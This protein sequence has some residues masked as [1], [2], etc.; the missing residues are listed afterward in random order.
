M[1]HKKSQEGFFSALGRIMQ[2]SSDIVKDVSRIALLEFRIARLSVIYMTIWACIALIFFSAVWLC[3]QA[4][5]VLAINQF[6]A[7]L[8]LSFAIVLGINLLF[9]L[10]AAI[11][12]MRIKR[13]IN[14]ETTYEKLKLLK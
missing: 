2:G 1:P 12:I 8:L 5:L 6:F 9:V 13:N 3:L 7:N 11:I 14:F 4:I 10:I